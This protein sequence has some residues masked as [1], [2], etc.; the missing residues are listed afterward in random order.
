MGV[1]G[2]EL[3]SAEALHG[4]A[5]STLDSEWSGDRLYWFAA[6]LLSVLCAGA[7]VLTFRESAIPPGGD[8]GTWVATSYAY[9]GRPYPSQLLPLAY[10]P[11]LFPLV[12]ICVLV[13]GGPIGGVDLFAG[14]LMVA[15]GLTT[16]GLAW[17][18]LR[19]RVL[20][21]TI[22]ALLLL[23]PSML[24]M[25]F[26]GAY[27]NLLAFA[28][29]NVA[30]IGLLRTGRGHTSSGAIQFWVFFALTTLTHSLVG[31]ALGATTVL[32]LVLGGFVPTPEWNTLLEKAR[33]GSLE[34]PGL[35]ARALLRSRGGRLGIGVFILL[36]GGYYGATYLARI[37]HP[38][39]F[40]SNPV[41]FNLVSIG[42]AF[43]AILPHVTF[44][45]GLVI[46][47]LA[48]GIFLAMLTYGVLRDRRPGWLTAGAVLLIAWPLAVTLLLLGGF[49][50]QIVTD[51]H[52]FG[53]LYMIPL[54]LAAAY[55]VERAWLNRFAKSEAPT[56]PAEGSPPPENLRRPGLFASVPKGRRRPAVVAIIA[57]TLLLVVVDTASVPTL[58]RD[59]ATFT[60]VGHDA[61]FLSAVQAIDHGSPRGGILTVPGA[62]KWAR[63][64][65]GENAFAPYTSTAYLFYPS[66]ELDSQ[67]AYYALTSHFAVSNGLVAA[68]VRATHGAFTTG[69]PDYS[70]YVLGT[71]RATLRVPPQL[72]SVVLYDSATRATLAQGLTTDPS[73]SMPGGLGA[74]MTISYTETSFTLTISVTVDA[75]APAV[76]ITYLARAVG[77]NSILAVNVTAEPPLGS[78]AAVSLSPIPGTFLWTSVGVLRRPVTYGNLTPASALRGA[79]GADPLTGGPAAILQFVAPGPQGS[80]S[81]SGVLQLTTPAA[82][83]YLTGVPAVLSTPQIWQALGVRYIL[84][85][86]SSEA[87]APFVPTAGE[88]QYL[89]GEYNLPIIYQNSEWDV[90]RIPTTIVPLASPSN[91][92]AAVG[93]G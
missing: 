90:L 36:V 17:S 81:V 30:L 13:A 29:Q 21:L 49:V 42:A 34:S 1:I 66:Q 69:A 93:P 18:V 63:A 85:R 68:S 72:I 10:P 83:T 88:V 7:I 46:A 48:A 39:Y 67:L 4:R 12:G 9:I 41:A 62:D 84:M 40:A 54:G 80:P 44:Q 31:L 5:H 28:F 38:Y 26:W 65:T 55:V 3:A 92:P 27:P 86:N 82:S 33:S 61:A 75:S 60:Q 57:V 6:F 89:A 71:A 25:F 32:Y 15:L 14:L 52:R 35:A 76:T 58:A 53:Y 59:E 20:A 64:L 87:L 74:P 22:V 70:I 24:A 19:S 16:A 77:T 43:E 45:P 73:V 78:P 50:G 11:L 79:T 8:P 23:D 47:I 56:S 51:Y 2:G 91:P 37:P